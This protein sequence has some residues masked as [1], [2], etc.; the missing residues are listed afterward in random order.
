MSPRTPARRAPRA[1]IAQMKSEERRGWLSYGVAALA[2]SA[3][4][5]GVASSMAV[6]TN[7]Q[8]LTSPTVQTIYRPAPPATTRAGMPAPRASASADQTA[9]AL[10]QGGLSSF[11]SRADAAGKTSRSTL[12]T[13][14]VRELAAA[15]AEDLSKTSENITRAARNETSKERSNDLQASDRAARENA[16]RVAEEARQRAVAARLAA[17]IARKTAEVAAAARAEEARAEQARAEKARVEKARADEAQASA[18]RNSAAR[19]SAARNSA[20]QNSTNQNSTQNSSSGTTNSDSSPAAAPRPPSA[21]APSQPSVR[22]GVSAASPVPGAVVGASFGQYGLWSRY[23]TGLDFRAAYGVPIRAVRSGVVLFA[24]NSGNWAGN[25]I[26]VKHGDGMTTMSSHMSSMSVSSGQ[27]VQAGQVIGYVGQT[28]R[29]FGAHLHFELYPNG[30]KYGDVYRA[31]N[32]QPWLRANGV[33][34]R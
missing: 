9:A 15:R 27:S 29:A 6:T 26:A 21:P 13:A 33:Q 5:L 24:G 7:A 2:I 25:H 3:L 4:G 31:V 17:V 10:A 23:H 18:A 20:A 14:Q 12:R 19:N 22:S 34:T 28:G 32:P 16:V 8:A 11:R 30:V 1:L